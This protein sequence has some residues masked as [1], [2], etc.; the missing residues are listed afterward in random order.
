MID[1]LCSC[2][3]ETQVV[4]YAE[5]GRMEK[6]SFMG[7]VQI[8][9]DDLDLSNI[10]IG[11][12]KIFNSTVPLTYSAG[13]SSAGGFSG[14]KGG[15]GGSSGGHLSAQFQADS[16]NNLASTAPSYSGTGSLMSAS[17]ESFG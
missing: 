4:V 8:V 14:G 16:T 15:G 7:L 13:G 2:S 6:K 3:R 10:V 17:M 11:W 12:Y 1:C 5:Y 9:L